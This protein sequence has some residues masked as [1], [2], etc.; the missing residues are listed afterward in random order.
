MEL[1]F[2][3][4]CLENQFVK[5][6]LIEVEGGE[7]LLELIMIKVE[8]RLRK[9]RHQKEWIGNGLIKLEMRGLKDQNLLRGKWETR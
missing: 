7:K 9:M 4:E 1:R 6:I 2:W 3:L 5:T 8:V